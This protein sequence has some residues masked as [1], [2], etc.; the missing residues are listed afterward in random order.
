M[1]APKDGAAIEMLCLRPAMGKRQFVEK[2]EVTVEQGIPGERWSI[3]PW[4]RLPDGSPDPSI[5]I[6]FLQKRVLDLIWTDRE[7]TV[8]PGDTFIVDMDLSERN[9][10][11]G[12]LLHAG[13]AILEVSGEFNNACP[14]WKKRYGEDAL[15]WV[16]APENRVLR[17]R[18]ILAKVHRGGVIALGD[19]LTKNDKSLRP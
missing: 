15:Q 4:M 17:P 19:R 13:G 7:N 11:K 14:K 2:I 6:C 12:S 9:L 10:P 18:G 3:S 5:Q 1:A 8:H 16:R